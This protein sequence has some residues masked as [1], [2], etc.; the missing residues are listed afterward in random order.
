MLLIDGGRG[1]GK[2]TLLLTLLNVYRRHVLGKPEPRGFEGMAEQIIPVGLLDLQPLPPSTNLALHVLG[3]LKGVVDAVEPPT[4]GTSDTPLWDEPASN[5]L[6]D[7]WTRLMRLLATWDESMEA[8]IGRQDAS[9]YIVEIVEEE[10][11]RGQL[12]EGFRGA[13]DALVD[14]YATKRGW[15]SNRRPLF[16]IAIDDADMNPK[17]SSRLL[18]L[19]RKLWHPRLAFLMAGDS[20]LFLLR[21]KEAVLAQVSRASKDGA[22]YLRLAND[23]LDKDIPSSA[24]FRL[25]ALRPDE[26]VIR[27][28]Q[29]QSLLQRFSIDA[30]RPEIPRKETNTP[31]TLRDYFLAHRQSSE[32]LPERL[33]QVDE[34]MSR[35][36][37]ER[38]LGEGLISPTRTF[39]MVKWLW[40][41]TVREHVKNSKRREHLLGALTSTRLDGQL[42]LKADRI[43]LKMEL[44]PIE[45][46]RQE[47]SAYTLTMQKMSRFHAFLKPELNRNPIIG[48]LPANID[49][50][51]GPV[52]ACWVLASDIS[53]DSKQ[54]GP[55]DQAEG[56]IDEGS[57]QFV[58]VSRQASSLEPELEVPWPLPAWQAPL[59]YNLFSRYWTK[60]LKTAPPRQEQNTGLVARHFL[61][62]VI[63]LS[64]ERVQK[65]PITWGQAPMWPELANDLVELA[66]HPPP[67]SPRQQ[68][69]AKWASSDAILFGAPESGLNHEEA[70]AFLR[71]IIPAFRES[72]SV[73]RI[74]MRRLARLATVSSRSGQSLE[75]EQAL[76]NLD[77][78]N[79]THPFVI[80]T[81]SDYKQSPKT[82]HRHNLL[83]ELEHIS[84]PLRSGIF[85]T[86]DTNLGHYRTKLRQDA[87]GNLPDSIYI[88]LKKTIEQYRDRSVPIVLINLWKTLAHQSDRIDVASWFALDRTRLFLSE[89]AKQY[90]LRLRDATLKSRA[91]NAIFIQV[92]PQRELIVES[93]SPTTST[94]NLPLPLEAVFRLAFDYIQDQDDESITAEPEISVWPFVTMRLPGGAS[95]SIHPWPDVRWPS[96]KE[97]EDAPRSWTERMAAIKDWFAHDIH[98]LKP[99]AVDT[100]ALSYLKDRV[101]SYRRGTAGNTIS[102]DVTPS[103]YSDFL[104]RVNSSLD[105]QSGRRSGILAQW[106][107]QLPLMATPEAGLS[108]NVARLF[109]SKLSLD[110]NSLGEVQ[111]M[112]RD[113]TLADGVPLQDVDAFLSAID[114]KFPT[115]PW[116]ERMKKLNKS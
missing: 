84:H 52:T 23:M 35:L 74:Q 97:Y 33:R 18:E 57:V 27:N 41:E 94:S 53:G 1:T 47:S 93:F 63:Q 116:V 48:I 10:L 77:G 69:S 70:G 68:Q 11:E 75:P 8:R 111:S 24:R 87:L 3:H 12:S 56:T 88:R 45:R 30:H 100:I 54:A 72:W 5:R 112:R 26:R 79:P 83:D 95:Q 89:D 25:G 65:T 7:R 85:T 86:K 98:S 55:L 99:Y 43:R 60:L 61:T 67:L 78:A 34:L 21:L 91:G 28:R 46:M 76:R 37:R 62:L 59:D 105:S 102:L 44:E 13:V 115:H 82:G 19:L 14:G 104:D 73:E 51:P 15:G 32:L 17:L 2:S 80:A 38:P 92:D 64:R 4:T 40:D 6:R 110:E 81:K 101:A 107:K 31:L 50:L 71:E 36:R 106:I 109:I 9:S 16:L 90:S 96:L 103:D 29:I 113:R 49:Y 114:Q 39:R 20:G 42:Q 108:D 58:M 66:M 22:K